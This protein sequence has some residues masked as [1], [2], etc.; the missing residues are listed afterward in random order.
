VGGVAPGQVTIVSVITTPFRDSCPGFAIV[1]Q[2][3]KNW[4]HQKSTRGGVRR[5]RRSQASPGGFGDPRITPSMIVSAL[6]H[7]LGLGA[8]GTVDR[9]QIICTR[10]LIMSVM[11]GLVPRYGT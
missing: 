10:P 5:K 9:P 6:D 1:L 8:R 3:F 7:S 11:A 2:T 4:G